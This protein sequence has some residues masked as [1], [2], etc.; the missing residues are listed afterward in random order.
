[1]TSSGKNKGPEPP[2]TGGI[3]DSLRDH[4]KAEMDQKARLEDVGSQ[5]ELS[6]R[7]R[8]KEWPCGRYAVAVPADRGISLRIE[9]LIYV[10]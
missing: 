4:S 1:M 8:R 7:A 9:V 6:Q 10:A 5:R 3:G 2:R